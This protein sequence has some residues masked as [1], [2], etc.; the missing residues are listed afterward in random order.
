VDSGI[1][2]TFSEGVSSVAMYK[3]A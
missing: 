3:K 2:H 1:H